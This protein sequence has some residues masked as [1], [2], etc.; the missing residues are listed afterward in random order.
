[1]ESPATAT[2]KPCGPVNGRI[3]PPGSKSITNRAIVCAALASGMSSLQGVLE[4][5]DTLVMIEAWQ[6]LGLSLQHDAVA[7]TLTIQGCS[8]SLPV[9]SASLFVANSGTTIRFLSAA[10]CACRGEFVLDGVPRMRE[11]P[12]GDLIAALEQLGAHVES[13]NDAAPGCPPIRIQATGLD[14]GVARVRGNISSQFL[15]GLMMAAPLAR[16]DV[17]LAVDGELVSVPYVHM[18]AS[19]M[20]SFGAVVTGNPQSELKI[21]AASPYQACNYAIEPDA[22]AASYFWAAAAIAGGQATVEG[23][24][25][26]SLQGDVGF[27]RVLEQMGCRVDYG[28]DSIS[29]VGGP[30]KGIDVNMADISDTVQTLAAVALFAEGPTRI[31]GV[32]HNRVKETD[33]ITDLATELRKLGAVVEESQDG[34]QIHPPTELR[35][36]RISTYN[37]HRMAMSLSLVG[38]RAHGIQIA[39]P[40]CTAKTYPNY[41]EDMALFCRTRIDWGD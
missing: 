28:A 34:L 8:G 24:S 31:C 25:E 40:Q 1:M 15:S 33:R 11:R 3:R 2:I 9:E 30:L 12:L 35:A 10:L 6:Q 21:S 19:V 29:V 13:L 26:N 27:C 4:S 20:R 16:A 37:D 41:W 23:L 17:I 36:T 18:T 32:A 7:N 39:N 22:S 38:L 14:G 5:E